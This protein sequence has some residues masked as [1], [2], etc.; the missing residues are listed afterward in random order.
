MNPTIQCNGLITDTENI[1]RPKMDGV[2]ERVR[3]D[4]RLKMQKIEPN[5]ISLLAGDARNH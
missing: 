1:I 3:L 2:G 5:G 4:K